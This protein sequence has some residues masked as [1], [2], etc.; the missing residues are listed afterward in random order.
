[1]NKAIPQAAQTILAF[2]YKHEVGGFNYDVYNNQAQRQLPKKLTKMTLSEIL[3]INYK[4]I[5]AK[6]TAAGAPQIIKA[7]LRMLMAD[8]GLTGREVYT[9]DLQDQLA[10]QLLRNRGYDAFMS[11]RIDKYEFAKRIASEWASMPVLAGTKNAKGQNIKRGQGMYDGDGLN[12]AA[13]DSADEFE[14]ILNKAVGEKAAIVIKPAPT[15]ADSNTNL[16]AAAS[17]GALV[18]GAAPEAAKAVTDYQPVLELVSTVSKYGPYVAGG[19]VV[20]VAALIFYK[21][22]FR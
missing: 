22:M 5:G 19:I 8:S 1:M 18:I 14:A 15:P 13:K 11:G 7:T 21:K 10:Y 20:L 2:V 9:A 6:S 17:T 16:V 12:Q 4:A 3:S